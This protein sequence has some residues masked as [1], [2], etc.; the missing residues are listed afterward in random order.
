M[1]KLKTSI[2]LIAAALFSFGVNAQRVPGSPPTV[3]SGSDT[4]KPMTPPKKT[5]EPKPY[6]DVI[7]SKAITDAGFLTVHKVDDKYFIEIPDSM[8]NRDILVVNRISKAAADNR[9]GFFGYGGDQIGKNVIQFEKGPSNKLFL[10]SISMQEF[11]K[12]STKDGMYRSFVNSN[13]QPLEASFDIKAFSKDGHGVVIDATDY[14]NGDNDI[15][16]FNSRLKKMLSLAQILP[17]R[18]Y[19]IGL[20]AFSKNVEIQTMK[21]YMKITPPTPGNPMSGSSSPVTYELNSSMV[22][23]PKVPMKARYFD[24]RVGYFATGYVDFDA[25]PQ[26]VKSISMITRW[27]LEPKDEDIE[28]YKRGEL[29]EPK[30]QIV[31]YI[32]PATPQKWVPYLIQGV[33]DWQKA[34]EQAG[35][36][37]AIVAKVAPVNDPTWSLDD[38]NNSAI[39][40][41][42][43][44]IA[45]A[46]GPNVNDPRS[47]EIL[48]SHI[49]WYHNVM[50]LL[51]NWYFIQASATD[52]RA[53]KMVFDDALMGQL[54]R[55][56]SSHEVGHTLG[57]RHNFGSS[58]TVPV[59]NL[60]NK[61]WLDKHGHTP[62]IM[63]YA[64]FNYVA[65]PEDNIGDAGMYPHIGEYDKWAIQWGYQWLPQFNSPEAELGYQN[66]LISDSLS[67]NPLLVFGT[68]SDPD[69]PRNQSEAIGDNAMKASEYG[70]KNLKRIMPN[71]L[72]WTKEPNEDYTNASTIYDQLVGQFSR[73][74]GHVTKNIGG[75]ET[76]PSSIEQ[77]QPVIV[78]T[79]KNTQK[80]AI[81]FLQNQLF[82][83]PKWLLD[84]KLYSVTGS[85][86]M[87]TI[88]GLQNS[89][90][91]RIINNNT[92]SK[93]LRMEAYDP[94]TAYTATEMLNDLKRGIWS[95]LAT[96]SSIDIYRRNLQKI[97]TQKLVDLLNPDPKSTMTASFQRGGMGGNVNTDANL[98][99][100]LSI[101]KGQA[102]SLIAEIKTALPL[103]KDNISKLHLQDVMERLQDALKPQKG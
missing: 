69:D 23:L 81:N 57:L 29:V 1:K 6:G 64:R 41:K 72:E 75:I 53:R 37:N 30:K 50:E 77:S 31:Y 44:N 20:K 92:I 12:D 62:S 2:L 91:G 39:V 47:G 58:A 71:I 14:I 93:L 73:Y 46:S 51:R 18:S 52:I 48:E 7:T 9:T 49:N 27:R 102:K 24:P 22:L 86:D 99:D 34:F 28:K 17:D 55:F 87:K 70:I 3:Q 101:I 96:H 33:N 26:G 60:R 32:D 8:L 83:T 40:Y 4:S 89:V 103:M 85:G 56:V 66:K 76:T 80:E 54:I 94:A 38:A 95:E 19:V 84:K 16:F 98:T 25:N 11:S 59:E 65:Q 21:T 82:T 5:S 61:K 68:E 10:K 15:L 13:L 36:K 97:Y 88:S 42:P 90:L 100:N 35:F 67:K 79:S 63:D 43:S 45:N 74:M 78:F